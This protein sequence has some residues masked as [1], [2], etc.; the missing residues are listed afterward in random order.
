MQRYHL[1]SEGILEYI[2]DLKDVQAKAEQENK[3]ITDAIL[4]II[5]KNAMLSTEQFLRANKYWG[6]VDTPQST[7]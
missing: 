5:S 3:P 6:G 4:I 1:N 7:W 2:N